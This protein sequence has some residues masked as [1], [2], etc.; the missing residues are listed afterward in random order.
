MDLA[1]SAALVGFAVSGFLAGVLFAGRGWK[2]PTS[3]LACILAILSL[4]SLLFYGLSQ[5]SILA[6]VLPFIVF[7]TFWLAGPFA[8]LYIRS[9]LGLPLPRF[10]RLWWLPVGPAIA[11]GAHSFVHLT[12]P[13]ARSPDQVALQSGPVGIYTQ[14]ML[15]IVPLFTLANLG[16]G[17]LLLFQSAKDG[18]QKEAGRNPSGWLRVFAAA[19]STATI[20][21][22]GMGIVGIGK[23]T[24]IPAVVPLVL[25]AFFV[26]YF[27]VKRPQL[28]PFAAQ[29][30]GDEKYAK[31][32]IDPGVRLAAKDDIIR[33]ME[34]EQPHL[35]DELKI[36]DLGRL[37][38]LAPHKLSIV[39]NADFGM[40][41]YDF[42]NS[43]RVKEAARLLADPAQK[44]VPVLRIGF[45]AGF[46]SKATFN[47]VFKQ[48][49]GMA[50]QAFRS[51]IDSG[52]RNG[53]PD[54]A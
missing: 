4:A 7:P 6:V 14:W 37:L 49:Y 8:Y 16:A 3:F 27:V 43:Y 2:P 47:R 23:Q 48:T 17:W 54:G 44:D 53:K 38:N 51:R 26:L 25:L 22:L 42:V 34:S 19:C 24:M 36:S 39:L 45:A 33:L 15:I 40:S 13:E 30:S 28:F 46:S 50:P 20:F 12:F 41:F 18:A 9:V 21:W 1:G 5:K 52:P 31:H 10:R 29:K 11:F 35:N 32:S